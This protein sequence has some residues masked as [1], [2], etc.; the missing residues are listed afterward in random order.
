MWIGFFN[1]RV[2]PQTNKL[3]SLIGEEPLVVGDL[4]LCEILQGARTE[5]QAR[6]LEKGLRRFDLVP[7]LNPDLA[8]AAA[9]N[10]R[11]LRKEGVTIRKTIDLIIGTFCIAHEHTLLHDDRD[12]DPMETYLGLRTVPTTWVVNEPPAG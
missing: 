4:M 1:G 6:V 9:T 12:F 7:M 2:T 5:A 8:I 3:L 11:M 10:Y